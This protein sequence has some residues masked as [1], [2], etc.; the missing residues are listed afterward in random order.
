M[1]IIH[2]I[3]TTRFNNETFQENSYYRDLI[4][5]SNGCLYGSPMKIKKTIPQDAYIYV[6]EMNNSKNKIEGIGFIQ[7]KIYIDKIYRIYNERDYNRYIY[8]GKFR[9]DVNDIKDEY[10]KKVIYV[11]EQLL[12]KGD[13]HSKRGQGITEMPL[14]ILNNKY[15]FNFVDCFTKMFSKLLPNVS[16][17]FKLNN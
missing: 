12:F 8:K 11:L 13:K 4:K 14:W 1:K 10:Y 9:L 5:N 17:N 3:T 2:T 16:N 6:I 15:Q 7:N